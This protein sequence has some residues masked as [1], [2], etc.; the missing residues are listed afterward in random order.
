MIRQYDPQRFRVAEIRGRSC[1]I[2]TVPVGAIL[3]PRGGA[4]IRVEA[5][6]PRDYAVYE[7]GRLTLRRIA[8]GGPLALV[9]RLADNR[10]FTLSDVWLV[11]APDG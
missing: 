5:W 11:D 6:L 9:R 2:G 10:L 4:K 8:R 1:R 3:R 7:R